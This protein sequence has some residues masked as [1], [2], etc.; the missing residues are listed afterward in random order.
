MSTEKRI[1]DKLFKKTPK[2]KFKKQK[3][4]FSKID[5]IQAIVNDARKTRE[6]WDNSLTN[7]YQDLFDLTG[8]FS[9]VE[10]LYSKFIMG[11]NTVSQ[12]YIDFKEDVA[13]L[14]I[15]INTIE[16]TNEIEAF[17]KTSEDV[18]AEMFEA[19]G[20]FKR[21]NDSIKI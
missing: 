14:G 2:T 1:F 8:R 5:D 17:I 4:E 6:D 11:V 9:Q 15:E 20:I 21:L 3:V 7:L 13:E 10:D 19:I 18:D 16:Y 12:D